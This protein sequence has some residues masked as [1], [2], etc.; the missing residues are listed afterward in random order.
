MYPEPRIISLSEDHHRNK[1]AIFVLT[2]G[3]RNRVRPLE[4]S[5]KFDCLFRPQN[6]R[7]ARRLRQLPVNI[8]R[9]RCLN[10][11]EQTEKT[12]GIPISREHEPNTITTL[13]ILPPSHRTKLLM[14]PIRPCQDNLRPPPVRGHKSLLLKPCRQ[15]K[16]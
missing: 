15:Q 3:N 2:P 8:F 5:N 7:W 10:G 14:Q 6:S 9:Q 16:C 13:N 11:Y 1:E 12:D 4:P